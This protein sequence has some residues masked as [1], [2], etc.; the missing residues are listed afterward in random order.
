M[1]NYRR[2]AFLLALSFLALS[3]FSFALAAADKAVGAAVVHHSHQLYFTEL[4][5]VPEKARDR[6]NPFA[7]DPN[8][9]AAGRKLFQQHCAQCHGAAATGGHRAP[10]LRARAVRTATPGALFWV[11]TNGAVRQGMPVWSKLPEPQRWQIVS[12]L[13]SLN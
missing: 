8:A 6:S 1:K 4:A 3:A 10:S 11:L 5:T 7:A 13:K 9:P 12:Y 2:L